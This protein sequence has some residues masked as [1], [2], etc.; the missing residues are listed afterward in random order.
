MAAPQNEDEMRMKV[1]EMI[2]DIQVA[3]MVTTNPEGRMHGR[4]MRA[5]KPDAD[6]KTL[7]FFTRDDSPKVD[8]IEGDPRVLL[9][10]SDTKSQDFVSIAGKARVVRDKEMNKKLWTEDLRTWLPQGPEGDG[11]AL[12]AVEVESAE[13]WDGVSSN[14]AFAFGYAKAAATGK[15]AHTGENA[16][17][18]FHD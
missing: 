17:V 15:P 5:Q 9:G 13:Y 11:I 16:K 4:P 12:I 1:R 10:Y 6:G 8:E 14:V 3:I 18:A 7:W 2:K